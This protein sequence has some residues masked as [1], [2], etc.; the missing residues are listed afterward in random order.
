MS[1]LAVGT[2]TF[3]VIGTL[4]GEFR[5]DSHTVPLDSIT[6]SNGGRG[7]NFAMLLAAM[8]IPVRLVSCVN[9][10]FAGTSYRNELDRRGVDL[11]H[12][13]WSDTAPTPTVFLFAND[14]D[15][16]VFQLRDR[17]AELED[18]FCRWVGHRVR[19]D[20]HDVLYCTSEIPGANVVALGTSTAEWRVFAPGHDLVHYDER[21]L[22]E[23]LVHTDVLVAN[24]TEARTIEQLSGLRLGDAGHPH[25]VVVTLGEA[26]CRVHTGTNT[27]TL[28]ACPARRVVDP[29]GAG[30]AF[31]AGLVHGLLER[32][33]V[34]QAAKTGS[35]LASFVVEVAGCQ[36]VAPTAQDVRVRR[37]ACY[38]A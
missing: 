13:F 34:I 11:R 32:E 38:S 37:L 25:T 17:S 18:A 16:R 6:Y 9:V 33:D 5:D 31:V 28:P 10:D 2:I 26:G 21:T 36:T 24:A 15:A 27:T 30:D 8:A 7:A 3:D 23:C 14:R 35:T 20:R 29:T 4:G 19:Q 22:R 1:V 12:L